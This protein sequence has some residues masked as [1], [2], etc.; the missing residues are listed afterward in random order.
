MHEPSSV[1]ASSDDV[2]TVV[3]LGV[4]AA[5]LAAI[6]HETLGHGLGC[7]GS[8]GHVALLTSIWFR[9]TKWS[10]IA[11]AGGP[12]GNLAAGLLALA[13]LRYCRWD[14]TVRF[15]LLLSA[16]FN[17]FWFTAQLAFESLTDRHDDWY[18]VLQMNPPVWRI[19]GAIVGVGGY[20]IA[21][22]M[23][24]A[25][26]RVHGGPKS[27]AIRLGYAAATASAAVAGLMWPPERLRS[28]LEGLLTLGVTSLVLLSIAR[29]ADRDGGN[30]AGDRSVPR[31]WI[32]ISASA[33]LFGVFLLI[34]AR[35]LGPVAMSA[36]SP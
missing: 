29:R 24:A 3:A 12:A 14:A 4:L 10:A 36:L 11:D 2:A 1:A 6:C 15:L 25:V 32:W 31:S 9:C 22:R 26:I 23:V 16:A 35:G 13:F 27:H 5:T 8:G 18:W 19:A 30:G 28:A 21:A 17:L 7:L 33:V 34:Q 20:V